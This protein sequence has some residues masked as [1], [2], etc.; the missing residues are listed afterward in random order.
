VTFTYKDYTQGGRI[1]EMTLPVTEFIRRF[2]LHVLPEG[3]VRIR[4]YGLLAN[5]HREGNLKRCRELLASQAPA[6]LPAA[7]PPGEGWQERLTRLT[8][9]DPTLCPQCGQ[10]HLRRV[11]DLSPVAL[12]STEVSPMS[13]RLWRPRLTRLFARAWGECVPS[14]TCGRM[15]ETKSLVGDLDAGRKLTR[16]VLWRRDAGLARSLRPSQGRWCGFLLRIAFP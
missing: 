2:L 10:G 1:R 8:G 4:Y 11:E 13:L 3:F 14:C 16:E 15:V 9:R 7:A 6:E 5:R 12:S